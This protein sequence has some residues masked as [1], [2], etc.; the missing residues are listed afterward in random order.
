MTAMLPLVA[1]VRFGNDIEALANEVILPTAISRLRGQR[2]T[3]WAWGTRI[4]Q[5][6]DLFLVNL[7]LVMKSLNAGV[8]RLLLSCQVMSRRPGLFTAQTREREPLTPCCISR[9]ASDRLFCCTR[10]AW[11]GYLGFHIKDVG[12]VRAE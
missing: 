12:Y 1:L 10:I 3:G 4:R 7:M 11:N 9:P 8:A 6:S 5:L 2:I